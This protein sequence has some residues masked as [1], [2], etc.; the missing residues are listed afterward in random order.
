MKRAIKILLIIFSLSPLLVTA[1]ITDI[2]RGTLEII[3]IVEDVVMK[4]QDYNH[5]QLEDGD[6]IMDEQ[7]TMEFKKM[8]AVYRKVNESLMSGELN[9]ILSIVESVD[10]IRATIN[11][12]A[13][14]H[15]LPKLD[16]LTKN[17]IDVKV[18][19]LFDLGELS[20]TEHF[21]L[22]DLKPLEAHR[23][24]QFNLDNYGI[25]TK[26]NQAVALFNE[27]DEL[28]KKAAVLDRDLSAKTVREF[29]VDALGSEILNFGIDDFIFDMIEDNLTTCDG[30]EQDI[31]IDAAAAYAKADADLKEAQIDNI[32]IGVYTTSKAIS[33][34][35]FDYSKQVYYQCKNS[36]GDNKKKLE[37]MKDAVRELIELLL[38]I[39]GIDVSAVYEGLT[40]SVEEPLLIMNDSQRLELMEIRNKHITDSMDKSKQAVQL[41]NEAAKTTAVSS[42]NIGYKEQEIYMNILT[43]Y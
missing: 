42:E 9:D 34:T 39:Y 26:L 8:E 10:K 4:I 15:H 33:K 3:E 16:N 12:L 27:V 22:S 25:E 29:I 17:P 40:E 37:I 20:V 24:N 5:H 32:D 14:K 1:Q 19:D 31:F 35:N 43:T 2:G 18:K 23:T 41:L 7:F 11:D 28:K 38:F 13:K 36:S 30:T 6:N 21:N